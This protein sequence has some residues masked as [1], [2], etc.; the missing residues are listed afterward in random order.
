MSYHRF[1]N[2]EGFL[3][4]D[5]VSKTKKGLASRDFI[6]R[7][8]NCKYTVKVNGMCEYRGE[9]RKCCVVYKVTCKCCCDFYVVNTRKISKINGT[10]LPRC[11]PKSHDQ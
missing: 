5:L 8:C 3:Q 6:D 10:T 4:G 9:C 7:E 11:P 1:P 2:L